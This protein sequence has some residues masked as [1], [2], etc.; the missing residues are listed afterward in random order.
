MQSQYCLHN[1]VGER[2]SP[3]RIA[4]FDAKFLMRVT[5]RRGDRKWI[6]TYG[7]KNKTD[8]SR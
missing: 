6:G 2:I 3:S 7:A 1:I 5:L 8:S 4:E